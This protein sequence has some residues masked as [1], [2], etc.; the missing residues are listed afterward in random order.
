MRH[1]TR[2]WERARADASPAS[3]P[4]DGMRAGGASA[5]QGDATNAAGERES[6]RA[7]VGRFECCVVGAQ[8]AA[9]VRGW[10]L[11]AW[12]HLPQPPACATVLDRGAGE[13]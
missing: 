2:V 5:C 6:G 3:D 7:G 4:G 10:R 12:W 11:H 9:P 13:G 8:H 1:E